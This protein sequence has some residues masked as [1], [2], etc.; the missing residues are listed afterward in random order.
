[1]ANSVVLFFDSS[2][3]PLSPLL[4]KGFR[5]TMCIIQSGDYWIGVDGRD[6]L[7][8]LEVL[9]HTDYD[10]AAFWRRQDGITVMEVDRGKARDV[11]FIL[12]N[13]VGLVKTVLGLHTTAATPYQLYKFLRRTQDVHVSGLRGE[14]AQSY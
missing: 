11:P 5:H 9:G 14:R 8:V 3:H 13:C 1:M 10:I 7:P 4:K 6:G 2:M 12:N